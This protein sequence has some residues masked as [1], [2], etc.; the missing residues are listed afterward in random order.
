MAS[1]D[2]L[3]LE[4]SANLRTNSNR[5]Q[6]CL[7]HDPGLHDWHAAWIDSEVAR[8]EG[9]AITSASPAAR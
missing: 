5:E 9:E 8:N 4:G 1:G 2:K 7:I 6:F 3:T